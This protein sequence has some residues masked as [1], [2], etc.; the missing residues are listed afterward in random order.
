MPTWKYRMLQQWVLSVEVYHRLSM[1]QIIFGPRFEPRLQAYLD[2]N[3]I[4]IVGLLGPYLDWY[5]RHIRFAPRYMTRGDTMILIKKFLTR[6]FFLKNAPTCSQGPTVYQKNK[7]NSVEGSVVGKNG[8][9]C[10]K[11][12]LLGQLWNSQNSDQYLMQIN[13]SKSPNFHQFLRF[14]DWLPLNLIFTT[15]DI[16]RYIY[17]AYKISTM[18]NV[19]HDE[20]YF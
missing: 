5:F 6:I 19:R 14:F 1:T 12:A 3:Q 7:N 8:K 11:F 18:S 13:F 15:G 4:V 2:P 10:Q 16:I 17:R 20:A 9:K